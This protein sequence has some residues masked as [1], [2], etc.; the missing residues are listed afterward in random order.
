MTLVDP[1]R[2]AIPEKIKG[3][4]RYVHLHRFSLTLPCTFFDANERPNESMA[5]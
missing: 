1:D 4:M 5:I 3:M 2:G